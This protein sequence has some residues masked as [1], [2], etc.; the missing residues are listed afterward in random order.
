MNSIDTATGQEAPEEL[1][2]ERVRSIFA[3]IARRYELFNAVSSFGAY[4]LWLA[5][6]AAQVP[7]DP[8]AQVL[9]LAG[10]AGDVTFTVAR[11]VRPAH[12]HCTDLVDDMLSVARE[13]Y[14][15]GEASGVPVSFQVVDAQRIPFDSERF[16]AV[17]M[18]YGIRNI[19]DRDQALREALRVLKPG[20]TFVC[21][22]FS[23][24]RNPLWNG[25]Y[26]FYLDHLIP[27]WGKVITGDRDGFVY[28]SQSIK[29]FPR[30][31]A[32][33]DMMRAAGFERVE[34]QNCTG[35][36]VAV[37]VGRRPHGTCAPQRAQG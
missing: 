21:L 27:F 9:D 24:P 33:A 13:R 2:K 31:D 25:L 20:G 36:I 23:T 16:D 12:I 22:E 32:F 3:Q 17:T 18:A 34:W 4:R 10:G 29:A 11:K 6:M 15:R 28:L 35:G 30:Q 5:R 37:H 1:S 14:E 7:V 26:N 8:Q 19:P